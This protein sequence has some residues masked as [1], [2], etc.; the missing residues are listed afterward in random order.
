M[1]KELAAKE[2]SERANKANKKRKEAEQETEAA[3]GRVKELE[4]EVD[5]L[6]EQLVLCGGGGGGEEG[7]EAEGEGAAGGEGEGEG[8]EAGGEAKPPSPNKPASPKKGGGGGMVAGGAALVLYNKLKKEKLALEKELAETVAFCE[9]ETK[10]AE[11]LGND[12]G[13]RS[14][15]FA[16]LRFAS[17]RFASVRFGSFRFVESFARSSERALVRFVPTS[18]ACSSERSFVPFRSDV[19]RELSRASERELAR[20]ASLE[21]AA[22]V[23]H[24][25][26]VV[27]LSS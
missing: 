22:P 2:A 20:Q 9:A 24:S 4:A 11:L 25:R 10:R 14:R 17:L 19:V 15:C 12:N 23:P 1:E 26:R 6:N 5:E 7:G 21:A 13:A 3:K 16:L 27:A 8:G 18:F